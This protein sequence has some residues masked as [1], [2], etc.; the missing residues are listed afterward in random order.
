[1]TE[2]FPGVILDAFISGLPIVASNWDYAAEFI[3]PEFGFIF[4]D[5]KPQEAL[6]YLVHLLDNPDV[7]LKM[8][9][10]S[11]ENRNRYSV[12]YIASNLKELAL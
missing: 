3:K 1:M 6:K 12:E 10:A 11:Y 4:S 7:L 8:Q 2:G 5:D 9:I